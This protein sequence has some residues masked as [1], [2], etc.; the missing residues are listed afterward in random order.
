MKIKNQ[1]LGSTTTHYHSV[2]VEDGPIIDAGSFYVAGTKFR[3][4]KI[5]RKRINND[6]WGD[7]TVIGRR[8][9]KNGSLGQIEHTRVYP[10][11]RGLPDW[12]ER[13]HQHLDGGVHPRRR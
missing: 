13:H 4:E 6:P 8:V 2:E 12:A 3:V 9:N 1:R 5:R 7:V 10:A 11:W